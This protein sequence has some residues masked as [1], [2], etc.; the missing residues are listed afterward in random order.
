MLAILTM[1]QTG[2]NNKQTDTTPTT[3][4]KS[5]KPNSSCKYY[6][7]FKDRKVGIFD[8]WSTAEEQIPGFSC[9][10]YQG[11][12]TKRTVED[13]VYYTSVPVPSSGTNGNS[14]T[15]ESHNEMT[16]DSFLAIADNESEHTTHEMTIQQPFP[17]L[18][19]SVII[20][21]T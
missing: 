9:S 20:A 13:I 17:Q 15:S 12:K 16:D 19:Y 5:A 18:L 8:S 1:V 14:D 6:Y 21:V 3:S 11:F 10:V 2:K 7:V 4:A